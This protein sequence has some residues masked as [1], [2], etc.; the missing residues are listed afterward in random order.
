MAKESTSAYIFAIV[1]IVLIVGIVV[2][3]QSLKYDSFEVESSTES[4]DTVG[5][6][7][8]VVESQDSCSSVNCGN[9]EVAICYA[10]EHGVC[11]CPPCSQ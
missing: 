10:T 3:V 5:Q 9:G 6:V 1:G 2:V 11:N 4:V 8:G 7:Y